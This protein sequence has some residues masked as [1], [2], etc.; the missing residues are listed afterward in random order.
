MKS[1]LSQIKSKNFLNKKIIFRC[2]GGNINEIGTGHVYRCLAIANFFLKKKINKKNILFI[3]KNKNCF[4]IGSDLIK[5][6]GY[7]SYS[8]NKNNKLDKKVEIDTLNNFESELLIIDRLDNLKKNEILSLRK[9]HKKIILIDS[10]SKYIKLADLNLNPLIKNNYSDKN[11]GIKYLILPQENNLNKK[12]KENKIFLFFGGYDKKK[13]F[14]KIVKSLNKFNFNLKICIEK[15]HIKNLKKYKNLSFNLINKKNFLSNLRSSKFA[16]ISGGL[17]LFLCL[18]YSIPSIS[19]PQYRHQKKNIQR[20][21]RYK[22]TLM[23]ENAEHQ[24]KLMSLLSKFVNKNYINKFK[25]NINNKFS[26]NINENAL[27]MIFKLYD[28]KNIRAF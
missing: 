21:A 22:G 17:I 10:S 13:I 2:D 14:S 9:K 23:L 27:F 18:K 11:F 4:K 24:Q 15:K 12:I 3:T 7:K 28:K 19:I 16:I 1:N 8:P 20:I 5:N 25:K 6:E 26:N